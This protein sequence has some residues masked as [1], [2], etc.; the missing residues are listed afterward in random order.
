MCVKSTCNFKRDHICDYFPVTINRLGLAC[1]AAYWRASWDP[2]KKDGT[3]L[4]N[5]FF[6]N[7]NFFVFKEIIDRVIYPVDE[8]KVK[9]GV[10]LEGVPLEGVP[11]YE[12]I[13]V[14]G[15][16]AL[17]AL[18]YKAWNYFF[19]VNKPVYQV[20]TSIMKEQV[21]NKAV[22]YAAFL[23]TEKTYLKNKSDRVK[24]TLPLTLN[25]MTIFMVAYYR[26]VVKNV[27]TVLP[28][29]YHVCCFIKKEKSLSH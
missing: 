24:R 29:L 25:L 27:Y 6:K 15:A 3:D 8:N 9:K 17:L 16:I 10:P 11:L 22:S 2:L 4:Y 19:R 20:I 26:G 7:I 1:F 28:M 21:V 5:D 13:K 23:F 14:I 12:C 18:Q